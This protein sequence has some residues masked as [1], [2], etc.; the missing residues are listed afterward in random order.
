MKNKN[1]YSKKIFKCNLLQRYSSHYIYELHDTKSLSQPI[2]HHKQTHNTQ[3]NT[4][5]NQIQH[6]TSIC[7]IRSL[8]YILQQKS[9]KLIIEQNN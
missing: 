5:Y 6:I 8:S 9:Y 2:Q 4:K 3:P 1:N 7:N